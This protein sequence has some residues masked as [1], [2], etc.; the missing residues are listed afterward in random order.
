MVDVA[1]RMDELVDEEDKVLDI[2]AAVEVDKMVEAVVVPRVVPNDSVE[3]DSFLANL[4]EPYSL[5]RGL[6]VVV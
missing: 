3:T 2:E 5:D 1:G 4:R 6:P